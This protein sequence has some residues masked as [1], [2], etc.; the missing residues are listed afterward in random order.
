[1][2]TQRIIFSIL[3]A[4]IASLQ[5]VVAQDTLQNQFQQLKDEIKNLKPAGTSFMVR[6][7]GHFGLEASEDETSFTTGSF[8]PIF[9]WKQGKNFL[10]ESELEMEFEDN[11]LHIGFEYSNASYIVSKWLN[12]RVGK[13][14]L[15]FG[16]YGDRLHPAWINKLPTM[17][18]GL[19]DG[20]I[21]PKSDVGVMLSGGSQFGKS[22]INYSLYVVNGPRIKDGTEGKPEESGM[23]SYEN[24]TDNNK[25]KAVG[26]R[27]GFLPF[28]NSSL[29]L[30]LSGY[31]AKPGSEKSP[32]MDDTLFMIS[33]TVPLG[34][35]TYKDVTA[36]LFAVDLSY[37]KNISAIKGT[38]DIKGQYTQSNVS[39]ADFVNEADTM[40]YTFDNNSSAYYAQL[41]YR[42]ALVDNN[43]IKNLEVVGRYSGWMMPEESLWYSK[44]SQI[45]VGLNYWLSWRSVL[46]FS[47]QTTTIEKEEEM[48]GMGGEEEQGGGMG[49]NMFFIH[50]AVGL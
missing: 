12:I 45:S 38:I 26:G 17:P 47:Y 42:P 2:K 23:L 4:A 1:M 28:S 39:K 50:L 31:F 13:F 37:V 32:F 44:Q 8:N 11:E 10:F 30:G 41:A 7:Y 5:N 3:F 19:M 46:K 18:L 29:E 24:T 40:I 48:G 14:L 34:G 20:G 25:N 9:L 49:G 35:I 36:Q 6:G 16:T 43:F 15:P 21:A 27:L 33:S 22:K